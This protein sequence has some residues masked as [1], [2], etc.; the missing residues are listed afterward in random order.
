MD[1]ARVAQVDLPVNA[2]LRLVRGNTAYVVKLDEN[3]VPQ[4]VVYDL[5]PTS[6]RET[7]R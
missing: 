3:D 1:G 6:T 7:R 4:V 5:Q 2:L